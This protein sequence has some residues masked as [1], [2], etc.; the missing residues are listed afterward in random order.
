M[1]KFYY[2]K[3]DIVNALLKVGLQQNDNVFSHSNLGFFGR[4]KGGS[5]NDSYCTAFKDAFFEVIG[6]GG[7][8]VVPTFTYSYCWN[9]IYN[10]EETPSICGIF[11]EFILKDPNSHRS[12]D[13]NFSY[14]A[15]GKNAEFFTKDCPPNPFG[16]D[17]FWERF[18]LK[19]GIICNLNFDAAATL[20]HYVERKLK[21]PYRFDKPFEG[22]SLVNGKLRKNVFYHF[23]RDDTNPDVYPDFTK[24]DKKA[25][26][27]GLA[28]VVNL[29]RGQIVCITAKDSVELIKREIIINPN[30]LIKGSLK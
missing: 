13:P 24:F 10:K 22:N 6:P 23:V 7:T 18:L 9:K 26:Q 20:T 28:K 5:D 11:S 17:S 16:K 27:L 1:D 15:L 21:V 25:K 12:D 14:T 30:F 8:L 2:T 29:G 3:E 4:L 19:N